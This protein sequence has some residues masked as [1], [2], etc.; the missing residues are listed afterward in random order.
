LATYD[1]AGAYVL[2][3]QAPTRYAVRQVLDQELQKTLKLRESAA[4]QARLRGGQALDLPHDHHFD[5]KENK[6]S[7]TS[8]QRK[9]A[10]DDGVKRDFFGR[11][12]Q[13]ARALQDL[14]GN[15]RVTKHEP[16]V[17]VQKV[18]VTFHEGINNAVRKPITLEEFM[19]GF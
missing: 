17:P 11:V 1:T 12:V 18:Y 15:A 5:D 4:R 3:A 9:V 6:S 8:Q 16:D 13:P 10:I 2:A 7:A 19:R 14:D